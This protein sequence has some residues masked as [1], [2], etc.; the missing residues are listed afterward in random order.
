MSGTAVVVG[1][2]PNGL[3]AALRLARAGRR[4]TVLER[5]EVV[6]GLAAGEEFHPGYRT[7]GLLHDTAGLRPR[8][9]R[10]L[11][12]EAHGLGWRDRPPVVVARAGRAPIRPS[13][14][15]LG[16]WRRAIDELRPVLDRLQERPPP[17][18]EL[19]G[20]A[21]FLRLGLEGLA[22]RRLGRHRGREL[23]R[24]L[25]MPVADWLGEWFDD[26]DVAGALAAPGLL[27]G[28][29]G[30]R[31]P[32]S[33]G[34][35]LLL[36]SGAGRE[37]AGGPAG[38]VAALANAATAAG[39][40]LR[41]GAEVTAIEVDE[42]AV[43]GVRLASGE[44][45]ATAVVAASCDPTTALLGLLP[46]GS[47]RLRDE[48][49]L[50]VYRSRGTVAKLHLA[51]SGSPRLV[52]DEGDPRELVRIGSLEELE[53]AADAVKYGE[54]PAAPT[55]EMR[56]PSLADA[57]LAPA[58]HQVAS[59]LID[60]VP[61]D[62]AGGWSAELRDRLEAAVMARL[63]AAAPGLGALVVGREL[64]TPAD[65][66]ERYGL[67][68]GHLCHGEMALDQ[69]L[70]LRPATCAGS[71]RTP[72]DGLYLAGGGSHPGGGISGLPGW[73]GA[74]AILAEAGS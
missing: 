17:R 46:T 20:P 21:D 7:S 61:H 51:L 53:R 58:G 5:R 43:A 64:L 44:E 69:L 74:G 27:G 33:A 40:E 28:F 56:L 34:I 3:V 15:D 8:V 52:G 39:V 31:A 12:L 72:I 32:G 1:A 6:G 70:S 25:P 23:L 26:G 63:E 47:L 13:G 59:V 38:L 35:L 71:Y 50:R 24:L 36:E 19:G 29:V 73:L 57:K 11:G 41:T 55:L 22:L 18:L 62:P 45:V 68:G 30:P 2:G 48:R 10:D 14:E 60:Y 54:L 4:V 42:G 67:T 9:V 65:I 16:P 49:G 66:E 37:V